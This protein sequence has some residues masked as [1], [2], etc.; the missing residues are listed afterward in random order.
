MMREK[1]FDCIYSCLGLIWDWHDC[2]FTIPTRFALAYRM[3]W[4]TARYRQRTRKHRQRQQPRKG[5]CWW[6]MSRRI[7]M[8]CLSVISKLRLPSIK[9][10]CEGLSIISTCM[11]LALCRCW[12]YEAAGGCSFLMRE[13][14]CAE[15]MRCNARQ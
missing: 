2:V 15:A 3:R 12:Y 1:A 6:L 14:L 5:V 11:Q 9:T 8:K 13:G 4:K 10:P 7:I